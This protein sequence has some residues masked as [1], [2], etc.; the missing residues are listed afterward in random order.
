MSLVALKNNMATSSAYNVFVGAE[1]G[2]FKA[3][4]TTDGTW[5]NLNAVAEANRAREITSLCWGNDDHSSVCAGL[6][7]NNIL[8]FDVTGASIKEEGCFQDTTGHLKYIAKLG[9]HF[10]TGYSNGI[11]KLWRGSEEDDAVIKIESGDNLWSLAQ[12]RTESHI[13]A[14]G[15]KE[16]PLRLWDLNNS[17]TA[18]FTAKNVKNDWLN[19]R[20]PVWVTRITFM[21]DKRLVI[22]GTG[23]HQVRVYDPGSSQRRPVIDMNFT[24]HPI[25]GLS[26]YPGMERQV[27]AGNTMGEM[28]LLDLRKGKMIHLFKGFAGG[29]TDIQCHSSVALVASCGVDRYVRIHNIKTKALVH[30]FYL[31]SR[32][33][34]LLLTDDWPVDIDN[35][36]VTDSLDQIRPSSMDSKNTDEDEDVWKTFDVVN[37]EPRSKTDGKKRKKNIEFTEGKNLSKLQKIIKY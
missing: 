31:K 28:G 4:N 29:I 19:L 7:D 14:T 8:S 27:I 1:T 32:L 23:H 6:R 11:V 5:Q 12:N 26:V 10:I 22:T 25:T 3:I 15:G 21:G 16:N 2:L 34:C 13:I 17:N 33:N 36:L 18:V 35:T 30:K 24:E 37:S 9:R 20:V